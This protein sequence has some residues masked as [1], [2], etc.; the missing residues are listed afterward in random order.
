MTPSTA[1]RAR[2][3]GPGPRARGQ[4]RFARTLEWV[5]DCVHGMRRRPPRVVDRALDEPEMT[6]RLRL[7]HRDALGALRAAADGPGLRVR[8]ALA[9]VYA[10]RAP[11]PADYAALVE[12]LVA[13]ECDE[14]PP[15]G[16]YDGPG[17]RI[18]RF[19]D[20]ALAG[21]RIDDTRDL[22]VPAAA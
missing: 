20:A 3:R 6:W 5:E 4:H 21:M 18:V 10:P 16:L 1:G 8:D 2:G 15:G 22:E 7:R 17:V 13:A 14:A 19:V 9:L 12:R 11:P